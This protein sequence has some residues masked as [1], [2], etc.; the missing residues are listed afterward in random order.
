MTSYVVVDRDF[1]EHGAYPR[2]R[3]GGGLK[4]CLLP[5]PLS[6]EEAFLIWKALGEEGM[7]DGNTGRFFI[8]RWRDG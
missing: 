5:H 6:P 3:E 1:N 7:L 8:R 2:R 4:P